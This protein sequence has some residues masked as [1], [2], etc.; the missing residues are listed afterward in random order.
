MKKYFEFEFI[1]LII[2]LEF[3]R[4]KNGAVQKRI[5]RIYG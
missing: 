4:I 3:R 5:H 1:R 2:K